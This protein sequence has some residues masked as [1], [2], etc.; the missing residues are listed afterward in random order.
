MRRIYNLFFRNRVAIMLV[1]LVSF[2][3]LHS[4]AQSPKVS[5]VVKDE[6]GGAL[7]GVTVLLK[8]TATAVSTDKEGR[9]DIPV[10]SDGILIFRFVGFATKELA[11]NGRKSLMISLQPESSSLNEVVVTGVFDKRKAINASIAISSL[12]AVQISKQ[13]PVSAADLLKNIP[14]VYV[15]S[16]LGE[17]RNTVYSR[18]VSVGSNDGA[19]GYYYVSMQEDGL[20]VTNTTFANY[21]PDYFY[22]PDATLDKLEAVRGGTASILGNNAPGGIF[23]YISKQGGDKFEGEARVKLG[24]EGNG[25]NPYYRGDL[26]F[27]G[28]LSKDGSLTYNIGGF[29]RYSTGAKDPGYALNK[30]GQVKGN[31]VKK[32]KTGSI[33]IYGKYLNDHNG[34]FE[35]TPT[36][37][38][39]NPKP[40]AG[41]S[42]TS[43]VLIPS[44]SLAFPLNDNGFE[45]FN[46]KSLVHSVDRAIGAN[47]TQH[48]DT[49]LTFNNAVRYS[50]KEGKWNATAVVY[51][52]VLNDFVTASILGYLGRPGTTSLTNARTGA[53]L[54]TIVSQSGYDFTIT[55][56]NLPGSAITKDAVFFEPLF[57]TDNKVK[58]FIDQFSFSKRLKNMSFTL[59]GFYGY[60]SINQTTGVVGIGAGTIQNHPDLVK[61]VLTDPT[62]KAYQLTNANG[63]GGIGGAG[64]TVNQ[65]TQN[66]AALFFGHN[67]QLSSRF[68]LDYGIRYESMKIKGS[69]RPNQANARNSDPVYGG[70]DGD[71]LTVYDNAGGIAGAKLPF[72]KTVNTFS[73]SAGLN[74]KIDEKISLYGRFSEGNKAPD[75]STYFAANTPFANSTLSPQAQKVDQAEMGFKLREKN[76]TL[77][78]TPFYSVLSHVPNVQTF[79]QADG[80]TSYSPPVLYGKIRT[81][82]VELEANVFLSQNL[83]VRGVGT[84]Q[85]S[86]AVDYKVWVANTNGP[87]DD[88]IMD[89]SGNK[90]DNSANLILNITP[91]YDIG[92]FYSFITWSY[93]GARQANAANA[94]ELPGFSQ[95]NLGSGYK[96]SKALQLSFNINN[97]LNKYGVMSWSRPGT[98]LTA[99]D[100]QGY[101]K[102][103][104]EAD[105][106][107]NTP[108]STIAIPPRAY[109]LTLTCKF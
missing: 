19:S 71:P 103:Q 97:I 37:S 105:A 56:N 91:T 27:G 3:T 15:N 41:F 31:V 78:I 64:L 66:Q 25:S 10:P 69:V 38:F 109:F 49:S 39:T 90:A 68:N 18:G 17:I 34:W 30:G 77:F 50:S 55:N 89:Y 53:P 101:T 106:K 16:S 42:A 36:V 2:I 4:F 46:T 93:L 102:A 76:L 13:A 9:F 6:K 73:Y 26:D 12:S 81:V 84:L 24:L 51:P 35:F 104:Y 96:F 45:S 8:G 28:P 98:F 48:I 86:K 22:R 82:G 47:W 59:G 79:T 54:A 29:Y 85:R 95:F 43:S 100:R 14:G 83:S 88:A 60:S 72:N 52:L 44:V 58:E 62:G 107:T 7:P 92:K 21:G 1:V 74:Y 80:L 63:I 70:T 87:A 33:K 65:A 94:F 75:L 108:Y 40:A 99:T 11:I 23:N 61:A 67:W 57:F 5:G 32:Y 20:P